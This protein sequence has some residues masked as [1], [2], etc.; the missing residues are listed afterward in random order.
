MNKKEKINLEERINNY[1][2]QD[3]IP[4]WGIIR[5]VSD[6]RMDFVPRITEMKGPL[7]NVYQAGY[8]FYHGAL[9]ALAAIPVLDLL[10]RV[11]AKYT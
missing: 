1:E 8:I 6:E 4:V 10:E 5:N 7:G 2:W 9:P 3:W 11:I